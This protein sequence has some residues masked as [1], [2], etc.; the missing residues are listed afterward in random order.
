MKQS[1]KSSIVLTLL[2]NAPTGW[3]DP[4]GMQYPK[5]E[6]TP[7]S[8]P[9]PAPTATAEPVAKLP[10]EPVGLSGDNLSAMGG[11][12]AQFAV[13]HGQVS[14][15][16]TAKVQLT[17]TSFGDKKGSFHG[18]HLDVEF[19]VGHAKSASA[20]AGEREDKIA[21]QVRGELQVAWGA[22]TAGDEG[23]GAL[24]AFTGQI[25]GQIVRPSNSGASDQLRVAI[26][27]EIGGLCRLSPHAT[28]TMT[29]VLE[30]V[31][32]LQIIDVPHD[33]DGLQMVFPLSMGYR[34]RVAVQDENNGK[35]K[36]RI[37]Y[38]GE[39]RFTPDTMP[40][41][42]GKGHE[43]TYHS[44]EAKNRLR[45]NPPGSGRFMIG[46]DADYAARFPS[47]TEAPGRAE[48]V[49]EFRVGVGAGGQFDL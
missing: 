42:F 35:R 34:T 26:G 15:T 25:D 36:D 11:V 24:G 1:L 9:T 5:P 47:T 12:G 21:K 6:P 46:I 40:E 17:G 43:R 32:P 18:H 3:S 2:L 16:Q 41:A 28:I 23:C 33:E 31:T 37:H 30:G 20:D 14:Y 13:G 10:P 39:L 19:G 29:G 44:L 22:H 7:T 45:V 49:H 38:V 48:A 4:V 8:T 27:G